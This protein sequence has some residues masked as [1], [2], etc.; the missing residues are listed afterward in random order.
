MIGSSSSPFANPTLQNTTAASPRKWRSKSCSTYTI[1]CPQM[2]QWVDNMIC[3]YAQLHMSQFQSYQDYML[4]GIPISWYLFFQIR[5]TS[6]TSLILSR[7]SSTRS[8]LSNT[9]IESPS[10]VKSVASLESPGPRFKLQNHCYAKHKHMWLNS[11]DIQLWTQTLPGVPSCFWAAHRA[12]T[13]SWRSGHGHWLHWESWEPACWVAFWD[14]LE[15]LLLG[16]S[17]KV[18]RSSH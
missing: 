13:S 6:F 16:S 5:I 11:F 7:C 12:K 4:G 8:E 3:K 18:L 10:L 1:L 15:K 17:F 14:A 9:R 2:S